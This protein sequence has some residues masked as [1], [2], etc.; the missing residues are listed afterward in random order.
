[1]LSRLFRRGY[2]H[3]GMRRIEEEE[4]GQGRREEGRR[5]GGASVAVGWEEEERACHHGWRTG[6]R[7]YARRTLKQEDGRGRGVAMGGGGW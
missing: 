4:E 2:A 5:T 3:A 6:G 7:S 1:M